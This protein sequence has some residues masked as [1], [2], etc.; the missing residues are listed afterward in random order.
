MI[1]VITTIISIYMVGLVAIKNKTTK[2]PYI[3]K[4]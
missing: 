1:T 3:Y 4:N 2:V